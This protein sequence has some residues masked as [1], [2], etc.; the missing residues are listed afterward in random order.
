[1]L[2]P[3]ALLLFA[4][5]SDADP[6]SELSYPGTSADPSL[7][8]LL[9]ALG[10][11]PDATAADSGAA[12]DVAAGPDAADGALPADATRLEDAPGV[13]DVADGGPGVGDGAAPD[14]GAPDASPDVE[15]VEDAV[16]GCAVA[17]DCAE[18]EAGLCEAVACVEGA[19]TVVPAAK[20]SSCGAEIGAP[21]G[22]CLE[23]LCDALGAC[24]AT[25]LPGAMCDDGDPCTTDE[26]CDDSG[27]C[28]GGVPVV[29]VPPGPCELALC[30][31]GAGGCV[32]IP[33][34]AGLPC[35]DS[36][37]C[38]T[39][40]TCGDGGACGGG[41]NTCLCESD[42]DCPDDGNLCNGQPVCV[43]LPNGGMGCVLDS[44]AAVE[45]PAAADPCHATSCEPASGACVTVVMPGA[46]CTDGDPC[47][48]GDTCDDEGVCVGTPIECSDGN[49]CTL[50]SCGVD[51]GVCLHDSTAIDGAPCEDSDACTTGDKC[52]VGVCVGQPKACDDG[53]ACTADACDPV[54]GACI[55]EAS[56]GVPCDDGNA[57]TEGD[58]C[59]FGVCAGK[60]VDC[61]D[62]D[63]C[64]ADSCAVG[65]GCA[66]VITPGAPCDDLDA[67]TGPDLCS[68]AG[69]CVA[70]PQ[71]CDDGIGCTVDSCDPASGCAFVQDDQACD[72][73][74][75]CT[76]GS[77]DPT[78][79]CV[80]EPTPGACD[81]GNPCTVS[82][83]C[84]SGSCVG[85]PTDCN[86][87]VPC[88]VDGCDPSS[89]CVSEPSNAA[90][91]DGSV[92]TKNTCHE[93]LG[94]VV[95]VADGGACDDGDPCTVDE[96]CAEGSCSPGANECPCSVD[97]DCDDGNACNG[98]FECQAD[99]EGY[100]SCVQVAPVVACGG[101]VAPPPCQV[102]K[103][104]P[105]DGQCKLLPVTDGAPCPDN[106]PCTIDESCIDGV[107]FLA[108]L[109]CD[110]GQACT[111]DACVVGLGCVST[112]DDGACPDELAC[113]VDT[114]DPLTGC[115]HTPDASLC[116]DAVACTLDVCDTS[117][118]CVHAPDAHLCDDGIQCTSE[119]CDP[120]LGCQVEP[121]DGACED[122][123]P[124]SSDTCDPSLGCVHGD[125]V[126]PCHDEN[127]CTVGDTCVGGE[128]VPGSPL[129]CAAPGDCQVG[130]CDPQTGECVYQPL[131]AGTAC[132]DGDACTS[133]DECKGSACASGP[134]PSCDDSVGCTVDSC[135]PA[136]GCVHD[137]DDGSCDDGNACT[138]DTCVPGQ[139]CEH[140]PLPD[141]GPCDDGIAGT[142]PDVCFGG[143]CRGIVPAPISV[144]TSLWC[145]LTGAQAPAVADLDGNFFAVVNYSQSG[146][147]CS[148]DKSRVVRFTGS[149]Q[150][151][152][153]ANSDAGG[154]YTDIA[155]DLVVGD[156]GEIG[157]LVF[158]GSYV[159]FFLSDVLIA[160]G[161]SGIGSGPWASVWGDRVPAATDLVT[162]YLAGRDV[163]DTTTRLARC[164]RQPSD[165]IV[166]VECV[167]LGD[168]LTAGQWAERDPRSVSAH[169]TQ[170]G[171]AGVALVTGLPAGSGDLVL[172]DADD[173]VAALAVPKPGILRDVAHL[174][175]HGV[176]IVGSGG[177]LFR[178][179]VDS[180]TWA[181][182]AGPPATQGMDV[183]AVTQVAGAVVAVGTKGNTAWLI[184]LPSGAQA[185]DP[186]AWS[187]VS[188]GDHRAALAIHAG[189]H[190]L[191]I[192]GQAK[193]VD[194]TKAW[195]WY[196][197]W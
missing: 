53:D 46:I 195:F 24:V 141:F 51:L 147:L 78:S 188:L 26:A 89:G 25:P 90:C 76:V 49:P 32:A 158:G 22:G 101:A 6:V 134:A 124:C 7:G 95:A 30:D 63:P 68:V 65:A 10:A 73:G 138:L 29:C 189:D 162:Y 61:D 79:G 176:W 23:A 74:Q 99:A 13:E 121:Q 142:S 18:V 3:T 133:P 19:C 166:D 85:Q 62:D 8:G 48:T 112:P 34:M 186:A 165:G 109:G 108:P 54:T 41:G 119:L 104:D 67:C 28:G 116:D 169:M 149:Q 159:D 145:E 196:L 72:D 181:K 170:D 156:D 164:D 136:L 144:E 125:A 168:A 177:R 42:A 103:C 160:I 175:D 140:S 130:A 178:Y 5:C 36:D 155:H 150:P 14:G 157:R 11:G 180:A 111:A 132:S 153:V 37:P 191:Y 97:S 88:T 55:K 126:G 110:D 59:L 123:D 57:C 122:G 148:G 171:V 139:G 129:S 86:D 127:P 151:T 77:C 17:A 163:G 167:L 20:G 4:G 47:T 117:A 2:V 161:S 15:R 100:T 128:C 12:P 16:G 193:D 154:V 187:A 70:S 38:T 92:C 131:P 21:G 114:C 118:G 93:T 94:C 182:L 39:D 98:V 45:C 58:T 190:A 106:D 60:K 185:T 71:T 152:T 179:E 137:G 9:D 43:A 91:D 87:G 105:T 197:S 64:T 107:C 56:T 80:Q 96:V 50:D 102:G 44:E 33:A 194:P 146:A 52:Q 35:Q 40:T 84:V 135:D 75:A 143:V 81:D 120:L 115:R 192:T 172:G 1:M 66:S 82:D 184:A 113:T 174:G 27:G 31:T 83:A 173:V 183:R 69:A